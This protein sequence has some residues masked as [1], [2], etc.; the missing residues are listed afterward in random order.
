M[1]ELGLLEDSGEV[2][3]VV[4][5]SD[6]ATSWYA[7]TKCPEHSRVADLRHLPESGVLLVSIPLGLIVTQPAPPQPRKHVKARERVSQRAKIEGAALRSPTS[8]LFHVHES[9][10][11]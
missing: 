2:G 10:C 6:A 8:G 1:T 3:L 9:R 7:S 4:T 5:R 11:A